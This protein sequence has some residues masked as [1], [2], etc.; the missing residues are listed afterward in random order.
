MTN[1]D[2]DGRTPLHYAARDNNVTSV[3]DLLAAGV[4]PNVADRAGFTA[5]HFAAQQQ[6]TEACAVLLEVGAAVDAVN[7]FGN[8]HSG[9]PSSAGVPTSSGCFA[10]A[11]QIRGTSTAPAIL[12][13]GWLGR[14]RTNTSLV[15]SM[16]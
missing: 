3:R 10:N 9:P 2:R 5:L 4:D 15:Y 7:R 6:A 1:S 11:V 14:W 13:L 16:T 12:P 8:T